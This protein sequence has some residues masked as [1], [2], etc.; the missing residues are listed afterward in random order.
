MNGRLEGKV[1]LVT[2]GARGIGAATCITMARWGA[3]VVV[4]D[5]IDDEGKA[6]AE[7]IREEGGAARY[8]RLDVASEAGWKEV[9]EGTL[10]AFGKL[11]VLVNNAGIVSIGDVEEETLEGYRRVIEVNQTGAWLGMRAAAPV[12]RASGG[13]A[14][15]NVSSIYGAVGGDG[16]SIAY[17]A[18]K[19]ALRQMTKNAAILYAKKGIRV[20][21][22]HPGFIDTP[23]VTPFLAKN[24]SGESPLLK[25]I[26]HHT[27]MGRMGR[28]EEVANVIAF[29]ASDEASYMTGTELFVDGGWTAS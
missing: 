23:M 19:G 6:I 13:G 27:P 5:V 29:A 22:V 9:V 20:L 11:H 24:E 1:A 16:R 4:T 28:S 25:Y 3:K 8:A 18:S 14:I 15:V 12:I 26:E 7:A 2:G 10:A 21:S 17:H